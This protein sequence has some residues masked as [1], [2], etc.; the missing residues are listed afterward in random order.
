MRASARQTILGSDIRQF[1]EWRFWIHC[2]R[3]QV[4]RNIHGSQLVDARNS[5]TVGNVIAQLQCRRCGAPPSGVKLYQP[6]SRSRM[7]VEIPLLGDAPAK[8]G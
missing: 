2:S 6:A 4:N 1:A 8:G 3:C 5:G 7:S